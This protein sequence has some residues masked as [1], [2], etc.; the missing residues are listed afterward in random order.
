V[1]G[2]GSPGKFVETVV[3][4]L[5]F[6]EKGTYDIRPDVDAYL[7]TV[8][9]R[10]S[11]VD[12]GLRICAARISR[13]MYALRSKRGIV[14]KSAIDPSYYD[15]RFLYAGA[16]WTLAELIASTHSIDPAEAGRLVEQI[17]LPVGELVEVLHGQRVVHAKV[18]IPNEILL[19]LLSTD[20]DGLTT[21]EVE[22]SLERRS[23]GSVRN[24]LSRL[25]KEKLVQRVSGRYV[26]TDPGRR[27][28]LEVASANG[29]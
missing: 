25:W 12:D 7:R 19:L 27:K 24:G 11:G 5:Q 9:S 17:E 14:H 26:L 21:S 6:L 8:E 28:A 16:Q 15:L 29:V 3:Q 23:A 20:P 2:R 18:A 22:K 4:A 13:A 1:L 10:K